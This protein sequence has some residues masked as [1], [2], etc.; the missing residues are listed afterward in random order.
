MWAG[1]GFGVQ[2]APVFVASQDSLDADCCFFQG[3]AP[4]YLQQS[5]VVILGRKKSH[6]VAAT[7]HPIPKPVHP[8]HQPWLCLQKSEFLR[9][10]PCVLLEG[11]VGHGALKLTLMW[12]RKGSCSYTSQP[13]SRN[14]TILLFLLI[15][16][17]IS[18]LLWRT[19]ESSKK[20]SLKFFSPNSYKLCIHACFNRKTFPSPFG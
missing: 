3:L 16:S 10:F 13:Q 7:P 11:Q 19:Q 15:Q 9:L 6:H 12:L 4:L 8:I 17:G 2:A 14:F 20:I 5:V 1:K 18:F